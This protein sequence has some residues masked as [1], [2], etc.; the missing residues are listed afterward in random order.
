MEKLAMQ[1]SQSYV[2]YLG[3]VELSDRLQSNKMKCLLLAC[4]DMEGLPY[5]CSAEDA[6]LMIFQNFGHRSS[7]SGIDAFLL[8]SS[9][10]DVIIYGH[11]DC[12][13]MRYLTQAQGQENAGGLIDIYFKAKSESIIQQMTHLQNQSKAQSSRT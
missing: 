5:V 4:S 7:E 2:T 11:S 8:D 13:F 1:L 10:S 6:N 9:V 12:G 3:S